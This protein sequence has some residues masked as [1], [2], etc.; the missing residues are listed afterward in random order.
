MSPVKYPEPNTIRMFQVKEV[1]TQ[2]SQNVAS[3]QV[4][5]QLPALSNGGRYQ[6]QDHRAEPQDQSK[7]QRGM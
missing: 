4:R 6:A 7:Q 3:Q 2:V 5:N 1:N